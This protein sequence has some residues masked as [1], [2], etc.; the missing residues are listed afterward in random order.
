MYYVYVL[1]SKT[2]GKLYKGFTA[3][4]KRRIKEHASG[5]STYTSKKGPWELVYYEAFTN[6]TNALIEEKF[7]KSGQ[8]K[9]RLRYILK[10]I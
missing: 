9:E 4:L 7:L 2:N 3:D 8:G 1:R 10:N 6:K 5:N